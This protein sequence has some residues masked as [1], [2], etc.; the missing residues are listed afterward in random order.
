MAPAALAWRGACRR[1]RQ[2][3]SVGGGRPGAA[4]GTCCARQGLRWDVAE[5]SKST[6][7]EAV[8]ELAA[9]PVM[10][11]P[12]F[13]LLVLPEKWSSQLRRASNLFSS[14]V[15]AGSPLS[16]AP[17]IAVPSTGLETACLGLAVSS[18]IAG[19][20]QP[21]F[22]NKEEL[23]QA[24][25][26]MAK[27][28][29]IPGVPD[30]SH[31]SI[32]FFVDP[33]V[34]PSLSM[35]LVQALDARYPMATKA[36]VVVARPKVP[37]DEQAD[38]ED[39]WEPPKDRRLR[40]RDRTDGHGWISGDPLFEA[41]K[42][43]ASGAVTIEYKR[44]PFGVKRYS[45]GVGGKGAMIMDMFDKARYPGDALGQVSVGGAARGMVLTSVNGAD[46]RDWD[47]ED[48]MDLVKDEGILD[49]DSK[50]AAT[51]GDAAKGRQRKP[52]EEAELPVTIEYADMAEAGSG[53]AA[54][55]LNGKSRREGVCGVALP[56][57]LTCSLGLVGLKRAGP[58]LQ[59]SKAGMQPDKKSFAVEAVSLKGKQMPAA[60][61]LKGCAK[62]AGLQSMKGVAV[63]VKRPAEGT[64]AADDAS[65]WSVFPMAGVTKEGS[66]VLKCK[67]LMLEGLGPD[68]ALEEIQF[69]GPADAALASGGLVLTTEDVA[70]KG[71]P[72]QLA[73]VGSAILGA[74]GAASTPTVIHRQA[75]ASL[76]F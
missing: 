50:S 1:K 35:N 6:M 57:K 56:D 49:P 75:S 34:P 39:E 26:G 66:L 23:S 68:D 52:V 41:S 40:V 32:L 65:S 44:R 17:L 67:G 10:G 19:D 15:T 8:A 33:K 63:G 47:F 20:A 21:F 43:G 37:E 13:G 29:P 18:G 42:A 60:S 7:E 62:A 74:G 31:G 36:G 3:I 51:W 5:S 4:R 25:S 72:S 69:F 54:L 76:N 73:I 12:S 27:E 24:G 48:V 53:L 71:G 2:A 45:P 46:V 14:S 70:A 30:G 28:N 58:V 61:A 9:R 55:V 11:K 64:A 38:D 22:V 16:T 59:V